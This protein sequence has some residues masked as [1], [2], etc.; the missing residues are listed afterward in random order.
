MIYF[1]INL[2]D[3]S[4]HVFHIVSDRLNYTTMRMWF[5]VNS[6]GK[7]TIQVLYMFS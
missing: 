7:A 5:L 3:A 4:K 1:L 6:P 2:Q